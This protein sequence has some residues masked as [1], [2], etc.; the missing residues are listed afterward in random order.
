MSTKTPSAGARLRADLDTAL[1]HA[2]Q[3]LG[4][5][6]EF[7]ERERLVVDQAVKAADRAEQLA[8]LYAAELARKPEPRGRTVVALAAEMRLQEKAAVDLTAR[9]NLGLGAAKSPRHVRA[10]RARWDA[11]AKGSA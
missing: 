4:R 7:D 2:S 11:Q 1:A 10:S 6:L 5:E 9:V 8:V 3:Q